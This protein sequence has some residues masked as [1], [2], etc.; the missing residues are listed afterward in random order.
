MASATS[1]TTPFESYTPRVA[2]VTGG[3]QGIGR[4]LVNRLAEDGIDV[5]INDIAAKQEEIDRVVDEVRQK[6]RRAIGVT[7]DVT[8]EAEVVA[9]IE[10]TVNELGSVDIVSTS[11]HC[12]SFLYEVFFRWSR[13]LV[14]IRSARFSRVSLAEAVIDD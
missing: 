11:D 4:G 3:A 9:M 2:I 8:V 10:K 14:F 7:A 6:G 5:A 1:A 12:L 13:T